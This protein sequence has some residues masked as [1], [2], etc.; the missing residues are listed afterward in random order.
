[1]LARKISTWHGNFLFQMF[2]S[3][4]YHLK[5]KWFDQPILLVEETG[6]N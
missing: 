2:Q 6:E 5:K 4:V 1:M 3:N